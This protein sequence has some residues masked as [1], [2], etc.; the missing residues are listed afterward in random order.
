MGK[1]KVVVF[2]GGLGNQLFQ[3][4]M[5]CRLR[6]KGYHVK[7]LNDAQYSHNGFEI[8]RYFIIDMEE[9]SVLRKKQF[10]LLKKLSRYL[11]DSLFS[12]EN[13][14]DESKTFQVGYWQD[15]I[16]L[17]KEN[18]IHFKKLPI[19]M[20]NYSILKRIVDEVSVSIHIRRGDYL[21]P[22]HNKRFAGICTKEYYETAIQ[23]VEKKY[24]NPLYL[25]FSNDM[26][27]VKKNFEIPQSRC[28]FVDWNTGNNSIFDMYLMSKCR[29]NI[30]ANSTFSYWGAKLGKHHFV[31]Y[32]SKWFQDIPAPNIFPSD[33]IGI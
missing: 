5:L 28:I 14:F 4:S 17:S 8:E 21:Q 23:I 29:A 7:Y 22:P 1:N 33:W 2:Q 18:N 24:R 16:Y 10:H 31:V 11:G 9:C 13:H 32:P 30:L 27:W 19:G 20:K 25:I 26:E 6:E 15:K 3:Y 12:D